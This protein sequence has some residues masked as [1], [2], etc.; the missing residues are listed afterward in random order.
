MQPMQT[1]FNNSLTL[2]TQM[3]Y[4]LTVTFYEYRSGITGI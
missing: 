1:P 3:Y 4:M 2:I